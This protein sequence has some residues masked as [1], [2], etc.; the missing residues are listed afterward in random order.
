MAFSIAEY[1]DE[2][3]CNV[4]PIDARHLLLGRP[5]QYDRDVLYH[6]QSDAYSLKLRGKKMTL[7]PLAPSQTHKTKTRKEKLKKSALLINGGRVERTIS[8]GEPIFAIL[9]VE[10]APSSD[11]TTFHPSVQPVLQEFK[12]VFPQDLPPSLSPKRGIENQIDLLPGAPLPNKP[13][14]RCIP[15]ETKEL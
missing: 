10:A 2:V 5:W 6:G 4:L 14:Y 12:D 1:K 11:P 8:K 7:T 13:A 15:T 9:M 3:V